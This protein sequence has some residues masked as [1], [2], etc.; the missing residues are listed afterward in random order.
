MFVK[1]IL[2]YIPMKVVRECR[3]T[4]ILNYLTPDYLD[5]HV[6]ALQCIRF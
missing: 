5:D 1:H 2:I 6:D 3:V 4:I